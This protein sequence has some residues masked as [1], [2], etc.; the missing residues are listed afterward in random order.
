MSE[1]TTPPHPSLATLLQGGALPRSAAPAAAEA[2]AG[3]AEQEAPAQDETRDSVGDDMPMEQDEDTPTH[4]G[5]AAPSFLRR[6]SAGSTP[7]R[8]TPRWQ[9]LLLAALTLLLAV[10]VVIA[11]RA[12]LAS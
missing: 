2:G 6:T 4:G 11:D 5:S 10:Q 12:T 8:R 1:E 3:T 9:W 7:A